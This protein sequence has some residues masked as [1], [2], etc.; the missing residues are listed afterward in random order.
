MMPPV[1]VAMARPVA[2]PTQ[3]VAHHDGT[4]C[5]PMTMIASVAKHIAA[6][7]GTSMGAK[8]KLP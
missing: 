4:V 6:R 7:N 2:A 5:R 3:T 8:N 1:R